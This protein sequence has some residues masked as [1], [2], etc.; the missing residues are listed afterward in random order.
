MSDKALML[1]IKTQNKLDA[2]QKKVTD[3]M[4]DEKGD[5]NFLSVI[6]LLAIALAV[7]AI[8]IGFKDQIL[9]WVRTEMPSFFGENSN[10]TE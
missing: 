8:F 1:Y 10:H 6:I 5:T 4:H 7:A 3:F 2:A 9:T